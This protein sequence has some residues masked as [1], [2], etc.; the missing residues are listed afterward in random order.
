MGDQLLFANQCNKKSESGD[1]NQLNIQLHKFYWNE[2][3]KRGFITVG[4][5]KKNDSKDNNEISHLTLNVLHHVQR[6][7]EKKTQ[8]YSSRSF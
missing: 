3:T 4:A 8:N 7:K 2:V 1:E 5:N 6:K